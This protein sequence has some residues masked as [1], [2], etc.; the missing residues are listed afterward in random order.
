MLWWNREPSKAEPEE[1]Q[2]ERDKAGNQQVEEFKFN[3]LRQYQHFSNKEIE[4]IHCAMVEHCSTSASSGQVST[5]W[6]NTR[7]NQMNGGTSGTKKINCG[8]FQAP[9]YLVYS[10]MI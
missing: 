10:L 9:F 6:S 7:D 1:S 5:L 4:E 3:L 2:H 8:L